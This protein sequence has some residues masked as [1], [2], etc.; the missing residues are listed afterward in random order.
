MEAPNSVQ[1]SILIVDDNHNNLF[2]LKTLIEENLEHVTVI[3]ADSGQLALDTL[4]D[5]PVDLIVLDVQMPEMDGFETARLIRSLKKTKHIP[6]VFLTAAYKSEEF[7]QRGFAVGGADYLT[8]PIDAPHLLAKLNL[9]LRFIEQEHRHNAE[10]LST[11]IKLADEITVRKETEKALQNAMR[12]AEEANVAKS[13]FMANMSHELRTPLNAIIG[14]AELLLE[15][16]SDNAEDAGRSPEE[17]PTCGD[18]KKVLYAGRHLLGL[19]NDV[20][21]ISKIEAGK[22]EVYCEHFKVCELRDEVLS[23]AVPLASRNN[24]ELI[25]DCPA[26][27][28]EI[29]SDVTKVRQILLNLL[30]NAC[31][32]THEGK[33]ALLISADEYWINFK[34]EDSGIGMTPEQQGKLFE[35]F[36][37]ADVS[38]TRKYGG[39]GLGLAISKHFAE[40]LG[41]DLTVESAEGQGSTF[42]LRLPLHFDEMLQAQ[43][44]TAAEAEA[45][46]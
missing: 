17:D 32:F 33:V 42:T 45:V 18:V 13:R 37:Q 4:L 1:F 34:V 40:M 43:E 6:I 26:E 31:K 25:S 3:E 10:L 7:Q 41:G 46:V 35:A 38:T 29:Y 19:I 14:Y 24:N 21:D 2:S 30:S 8:K 44:K 23:T 22:M 16:A 27:I 20:L 11:N 9:Y 5:N 12:A 39:T 28:T 15:D 36:T